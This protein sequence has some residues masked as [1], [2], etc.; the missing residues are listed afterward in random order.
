MKL[1]IA[2]MHVVALQLLL[3][4]SQFSSKKQG[5]YMFIKSL[6]G[7]GV[8]NKIKLGECLFWTDCL[9]E[10]FSSLLKPQIVGDT[11]PF[12]RQTG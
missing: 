12:I 11:L 1:T 2:K 10:Y 3:H 6:F 9:L 5:R 7:H 8:R 4:F